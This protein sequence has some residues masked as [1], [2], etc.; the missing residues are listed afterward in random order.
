MKFEDSWLE[1]I[2]E[3]YG[4]GEEPVATSCKHSKEPTVFIKR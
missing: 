3:S 2:I 4:S 1:G